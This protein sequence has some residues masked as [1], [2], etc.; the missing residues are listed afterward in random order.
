MCSSR[1]TMAILNFYLRTLSQLRQRL[2]PAFE[3]LDDSYENYI[4]HLQWSPLFLRPASVDYL[5]GYGRRNGNPTSLHP[6]QKLLVLYAIKTRSWNLPQPS[7]QLALPKSTVTIQQVNLSSTSISAMITPRQ[8]GFWFAVYDRNRNLFTC[9][10][11]ILIISLFI[12][13]LYS[14]MERNRFIM[15][16]ITYRSTLK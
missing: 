14:W 13:H 4:A 2:P 16:K 6:P 10:A 3:D 9:V 15:R 1:M 12:L 8:S 5:V 11:S 7:I